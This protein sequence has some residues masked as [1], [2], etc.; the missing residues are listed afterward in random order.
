MSLVHKSVEKADESS[1]DVRV[2][3]VW[4]AW[5]SWGVWNNCL[6][7]DG[8]ILVGEE[9]NGDVANGEVAN[10]DEAVGEVSK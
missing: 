7:G 9:A 3:N 2:Q 8:Y 10:G 4:K 6:V 5:Y 1:C